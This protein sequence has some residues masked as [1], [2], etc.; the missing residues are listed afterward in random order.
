MYSTA[1]NNG[2]FRQLIWIKPVKTIMKVTYIESDCST[3][4]EDYIKQSDKS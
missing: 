3:Q 4:T 1:I 2:V